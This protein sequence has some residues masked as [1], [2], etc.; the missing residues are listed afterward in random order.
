MPSVKFYGRHSEVVSLIVGLV[1]EVIFYRRSC[2]G[3]LLLI[4]DILDL[5][6]DVLEVLQVFFLHSSLIFLWHKSIS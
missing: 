1:K 4:L 6:S 5:V 2:D 3:I